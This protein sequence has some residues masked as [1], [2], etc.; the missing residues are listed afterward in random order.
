M[1]KK[2]LVLICLAAL[3]GVICMA[4]LL[5]AAEVPDTVTIQEKAFEKFKKGPVTL[6]HKKHSAEYGVKCDEC[7]HLYKDGKNTWKE[8]DAVQK[9]S[10]CHDPKKKNGEAPK[11]QNA[12]HSNCKDCHKAKGKGPEKKCGECHA[13]K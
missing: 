7:H 12:F 13:E 2:G 5:V 6:D 10:E 3:I 9:C 4:G 11:L 1:R 8:G